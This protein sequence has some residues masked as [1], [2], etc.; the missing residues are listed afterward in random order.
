MRI[1]LIIAFS[2]LFASDDNAPT[3]RTRD[4][5]VDIH[6]IKID[7]SVDLVSESVYGYVVHQL[8][9]LHSSLDSFELDAED[10]TI[11]R[12]RLNDYDV[13]FNPTHQLIFLKKLSTIFAE[14][15]AKGIPPPG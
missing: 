2:L 5:Q 9:P 7:I 11:R 14:E 13:N 12:V 8:S 10:M 1:F 3:H 15:R 4:R 6:H